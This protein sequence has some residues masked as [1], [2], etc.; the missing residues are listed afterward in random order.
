M[1]ALPFATLAFSGC[2]GGGDAPTAPVPAP[3]APA[4]LA[5]TIA[6]GGAPA[7]ASNGVYAVNPGQTVDFSANKAVTWTP[8][9]N[10]VQLRSASS[11][12]TSYSAQ[13][14]NPGKDPVEWSMAAASGA[15]S[16]VIRFRLAGG[17]ASNGDYLMFATNGIRY[18]LSLNLDV[19]EYQIVTDLP[20]AGQAVAS[21]RVARDTAGGAD[22]Y[23]FVIAPPSGQLSTA[24]FRLA[25]NAVIGGYVFPPATLP[26]A[27]V[28]AREFATAA[29]DLPATLDHQMFGREWSSTGTIDSS[30]YTARF[31]GTVYT[32]CYRLQIQPIDTCDVP[33]VYDLTFNADRS[34]RAVARPPTVDTA[35]FYVVRIGRDWV[36]LRASPNM[37]GLARFRIGIPLQ[38]ALN[39]NTTLS[40]IRGNWGAL[41]ASSAG[42]VFSG[43]APVGSPTVPQAALINTGSAYPPGLFL[44]GTIGGEQHFVGQSN[45]VVVINGAR[46][47]AFPSVNSYV[48]I[49]LRP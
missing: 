7:V 47:A 34:V 12:A 20:P 22:H 45:H 24:R 40:D 32:I 42:T 13:T 1:L 48:G 39:A 2:G 36:H 43:S 23:E 29:S 25:A 30:I 33:T 19:N 38:S 5:V 17:N 8:T 21:G 41:T 31:N 28:A 6:V 35:F 16:Q 3:P 44:V 14:L 49:G 4:A 27:F 18:K 9:T 11:T 10:G 46:N 37:N 15:E 26:T